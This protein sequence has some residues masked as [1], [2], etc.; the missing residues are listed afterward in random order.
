MPQQNYDFF[1]EGV[2][3]TYNVGAPDDPDDAPNPANPGGISNNELQRRQRALQDP[4]YR[5]TFGAGA[6][7]DKYGNP[8]S[9]APAGT[10]VMTRRDSNGRPLNVV[11]DTEESRDTYNNQLGTVAS[12][13]GS[14]ARV[15]SPE[16]L[17]RIG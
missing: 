6:G 12:G 3:T 1:G 13:A 8:Y 4:T 15:Q 17:Q 11:A 2:D 16:I 10:T 14:F 9:T 5:P 7:L